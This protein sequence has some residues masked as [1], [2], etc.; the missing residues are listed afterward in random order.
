MIAL[1]DARR[2]LWT[3]ET[4]RD[5]VRRSYPWFLDTYNGYGFPVQRVDATKYFLML[6]YGGI[7]LDLGN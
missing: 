7:Y 4:P 3:E 5:F 2:M 1:S 6:H